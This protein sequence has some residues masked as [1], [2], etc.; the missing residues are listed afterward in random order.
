MAA[1][2]PQLADLNEAVP[3]AVVPLRDEAGEQIKAS[4]SSDID[5]CHW[6]AE[7]RGGGLPGLTLR[8]PAPASREKEERRPSGFD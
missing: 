8:C 4:E 6:V 2:V 1:S 7:D 5:L 3:Y